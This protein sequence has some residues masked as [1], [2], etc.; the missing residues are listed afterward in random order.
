MRIET[1]GIVLNAIMAVLLA[2]YGVWLK[3]IFA[4]QLGAKDSTIEALGAAIKANEAEI[5][6]LKGETAPAIADSYMKMKDFA[7]AMATKSNDLAGRLKEIENRPPP[8]PSPSERLIGRALGFGE[9]ASLFSAR[10]LELGKGPHIMGKIPPGAL[11]GAV[12]LFGMD[13]A[14]R[15]AELTVELGQIPKP[16]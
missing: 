3:Y 16:S 9:A 5:A 13:I 15:S 12:N 7:D 10:L 11:W 8:V 1:W 4:R 14:K 2:G 6:R